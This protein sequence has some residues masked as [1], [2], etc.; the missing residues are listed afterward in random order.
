M[1][2]NM[3]TFID[4]LPSMSEVDDGN[5]Y[6][7]IPP[8]ESNKIKRMIRNH[9][10]NIPIESGMN[11]KNHQL[12]KDEEMQKKMFEDEQQRQLQEQQM[13]LQEQQQ[14]QMR[15]QYHQNHDQQED[16]IYDRRKNK[17]RHHH[18]MND[19]LSCISVAE[20]T[21]NCMVCSKLYNDDRS[22]YSGVII[23][24]LIISLILLKKVVEK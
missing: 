9:D 24:L 3:V 1:N 22:I 6:P 8:S 21:T 19:D 5:M 4:E 23:V 14:Q 13:K 2:K 16:Y 17:R 11:T 10:H 18:H 15:E 12:F 20:H 7:M